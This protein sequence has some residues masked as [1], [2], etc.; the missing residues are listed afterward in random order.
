MSMVYSFQIESM[1]R[2]YRQ[3]KGI[4]ESPSENDALVCER[5]IGN[6]H[7]THAVAIRKD[8]DG[9]AR[10][11]SKKNLFDLFYFYQTR[12]YNLL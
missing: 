11:Y 7:D 1:I 5:E 2:G 4:W 6:A 10:T 8:I 9:E 3:Y 12:R